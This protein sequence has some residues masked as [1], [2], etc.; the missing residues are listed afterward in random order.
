VAFGNAP[1]IL[2]GAFV[3]YGLSI[4]PL[5][6]VFQFNP[7]ELSRSRS[8][9]FS[10]PNETI[11]CPPRRGSETSDASARCNQMQREQSLRDFHKRTGDLMDIQEQQKVAVQEE[12]LNFD[13]RL[14]ATDKLAE[15]D[16]IAATFGVTP[17][18]ATLELMVHPKEESLLAAALG[19]L[20][21]SSGGFSFTE[22][23]NPPMILFIWGIKRVLPV[24]INSINIKETEFS[25]LLD[26]VR[27]TASVSLTVIE[28]SNPLYSYSKVMKEVSSVLNLANI[29][30][31]ANVVVPG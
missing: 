19:D 26:P 1:K 15:G 2:R 7:V 22:K 13:I 12:T 18:L 5:F 3:E 31:I 29:A 21:G 17:Q 14:D 20:L 23:T 16:P 4:P 30:D 28:G 9:S 24:N 6:V 25:T 27:A 8:L 11:A 10:A